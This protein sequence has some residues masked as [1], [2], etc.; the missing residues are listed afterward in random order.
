MTVE[1]MLVWQTADDEEKGGVRVS[2][3]DRF[4]DNDDD[5]NE[6]D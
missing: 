6:K 3:R 5:S 2:R 4:E 1:N